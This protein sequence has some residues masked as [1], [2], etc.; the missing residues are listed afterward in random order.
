MPNHTSITLLTLFFQCILKKNKVFL[1][2]THVS[3]IL[4]NFFSQQFKLLLHSP[5]HYRSNRNPLG[6]FWLWA[7]IK[8]DL[9]F[10]F[11]FL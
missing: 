5:G 6:F 11:L 8:L 3:I 9:A 7:M 1:K 10:I 2:K 4:W